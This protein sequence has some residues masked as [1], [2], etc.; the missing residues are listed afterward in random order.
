MPSVS[1]VIVNWNGASLLPDCLGSLRSQT[2]PDFEI[3]L[4]DN[5]STD[6]SVERARALFPGI[7]VV[8]VGRNAGFARGSNLGIREARGRYVVLLN[9]DTAAEPRFLEELVSAAGPGPPVGMVAPKILSFF[10]PGVIDS[11]GGLVLTPDGIGQGRGRGEL[12]RGQYDGLGRVLCP[13]GCA[14]LYRRDLL[15]DVGPLAEEFFAYCEDSEIGLRATW[16][17]WTAVAAPKA[18]VRH[19]Y[20]ASAGTYSA[21]KLRLVER[22]HY[23]LALRA[24]PP[25]LLL[26][27]PLWSL[28][29]FGVMAYSL[30]HRKGRGG[31]AG[32][33]AGALFAAFA[34]GHLEALGGAPA[35]LARRRRVPRRIASAD[36]LAHLR[37]HRIPVGRAFLV[38]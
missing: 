33:H 8:E 4:V 10:E 5:G 17:G 15:D 31:G 35:Q 20:S 27:M 6:A 36:F 18:V 7:R 13:S 21:L 12:D 23:W 9:N 1:V 25:S 22:N 26:Q 19:K 11:V 2:F 24:F 14:A 34:L 38:P 32:G 16:A 3:V 29:R 28:Q 30:L 37:S